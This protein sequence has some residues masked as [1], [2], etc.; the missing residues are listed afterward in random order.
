MPRLFGLPG[1]AFDPN[2]SSQARE[3]WRSK[4]Q[5]NKRNRNRCCGAY[6]GLT[7]V[8]WGIVA[9]T[10]WG[11]LHLADERLIS[12]FNNNSRDDW[13][14]KYVLLQKTFDGSTASFYSSTGVPLGDVVFTQEFERW[15]MEFGNGTVGSIGL[16]EVVYNL[17]SNYTS[18]M[19]LTGSCQS[20]A[21][22]SNHTCFTGGLLPIDFSEN[23][24][25]DKSYP[26]EFQH[27]LDL[28]MTSNQTGGF[29]TSSSI[30]D[31]FTLRT[32]YQG[33][34]LTLPPLGEWYLNSTTI[35]H[36]FWSTDSNRACDGLRINLSSEFEVASW[37]IFGIIWEWWKQWGENGG[38]PWN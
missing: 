4:H 29:N 19:N 34:G 30:I 36:V 37:S 8:Y 1:K 27:S 17:N 38:C 28:T 20:N 33:I 3:Q 31:V 13:A 25:S 26:G 10:I 21:N 5:D 11:V 7:V 12:S 16:K 9:V 6:C 14:G 22:T 32:L 23:M 18:A 15:T 35:L 24:P 2:W